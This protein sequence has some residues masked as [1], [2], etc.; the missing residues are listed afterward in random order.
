MAFAEHGLELEDI[1][2]R[3]GYSRR[4]LELIF[5]SNTGMPPGRWFMNIR[6]NGVM[7]DLLTAT[8]DCLVIDVASKWGFRHLSRFSYQYRRAF[9]EL[10]SETLRRATT[11]YL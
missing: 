7:R 6:L 5:K 2:K 4:A 1:S 10:P 3:S 9:G 8:P 11:R